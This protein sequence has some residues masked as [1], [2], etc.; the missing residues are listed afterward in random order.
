M[1]GIAA[2]L[3]TAFAVFAGTNVDDVVI[4][5]VLFLSARAKG[6]LHPWQIVTGQYTPSGRRPPDLPPVNFPGRGR[7]DHRF[8][9]TFSEGPGSRTA[10]CLCQNRTMDATI[11]PMPVAHRWAGRR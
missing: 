8:S 6:R 2:T 5:T 11:W 4:L 9:R 7:Q 1:D 10:P 3:G